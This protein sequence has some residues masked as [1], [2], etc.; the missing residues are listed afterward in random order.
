MDISIP[1]S[2]SKAKPNTNQHLTIIDLYYDNRKN[3][4]DICGNIIN[5]ENY[6][7]IDILSTYLTDIVDSIDAEIKQST[8]NSM[9]NWREKKNPKLLS[10]FINSDDN[11][12]IINRSMNKITA[13]NYMVIVSEIT[14][15]LTQ[16]NFRKLPDY[17][18]FLFDTVIKKCLNDESFTKDY[19]NFLIGFD[20]T[21]GKYIA[22]YINQ[23]IIEMYSILEKNSDLKSFVYFS[24][25]KDITNYTNLGIIFANLYIIQNEKKTQY[26]IA[27]DII[28][29]KFIRSLFIINSFLDWIP[30][31]IDEL[32]GR[33]Y[34]L[35]GIF[36][37]I[38]KNIFKMMKTEDRILMRNILN[39]IYNINSIPNKIK[40]KVLDIQDII[41][42]YEKENSNIN[43]NINSN[44]NIESKHSAAWKSSINIVIKK[45]V[46]KEVDAKVD[47]TVVK[48]VEVKTLFKPH[49]GNFLSNKEQTN[50][51]VI[52]KP[53]IE[54]FPNNNIFE[55]KKDEIIENNGITSK[56]KKDQ[57]INTQ[58][59]NN[60]QRHYRNNSNSQPR[61]N[62][63]QQRNNS[64]SQPRNNDN[65]Q[66]N[67]SN[68]QQRNR[69]RTNN[70]NNTNNK[71]I[72]NKVNLQNID[73]KEVR[74][75]EAIIDDGFI[76]IE[77]KNKNAID[78]SNYN[79][80]NN[81]IYRPNKK[82]NIK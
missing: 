43:S 78:N 77:R 50:I 67:N 10:K 81:N 76:K 63:N 26:K 24:Y 61:N 1:I 49:I 18:K 68:N 21:I 72:V 2:K 46:V 42:I 57:N 33:I 73:N 14:E 16:D 59:I 23:F 11:I 71:Y 66:R 40:F 51:K 25:V 69:Q 17:S 12:N 38:G 32:N 62:D 47:A 13:T 7:F 30:S 48:E 54:E 22:Q 15:T 27:D 8:R 56:L 9:I 36:E 79:T 80:N 35:F 74:E 58:H 3:L 41:N 75:D 20:G 34:M 19:L 5:K 37:A 29:D 55:I 44:S 39:L 4:Y 31:E 64:N 53:I 65:Q 70:T 60:R 52:T 28:Y 45:E 6:K 82:S